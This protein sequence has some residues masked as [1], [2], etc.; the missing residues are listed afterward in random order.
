[1]LMFVCYVLLNLLISEEL[2]LFFTVSAVYLKALMCTS[3]GHTITNI[4]DLLGLVISVV[5]QHCYHY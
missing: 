2:V 3:N 5:A 1:M 4:T